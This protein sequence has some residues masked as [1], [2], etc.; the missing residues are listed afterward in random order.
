LS[1]KWI[2]LVTPV[3]ASIA[4]PLAEGLAIPVV[5]RDNRILDIVPLPRTP[6]GGAIRTALDKMLTHQVDTCWFD[7]GELLPP[8]WAACGDADWAGGTLMTC[9]YRVR[10]KGDAESVWE[11]VRTIG[12]DRGWYYAQPLWRLRGLLDRLVG[13]VGLRRGRRHPEELG[14]GDGIDF[15]RV[16]EIIEKRKL[17]LLA[18][19]K[20]PG[21]ATLTFEIDD[22][23]DGTTQL[24]LL[25][26]FLP[27]GIAGIFYWYSFYPF[28]ERIFFGMARAMARVTGNAIQGK[29]ERFTPRIADSC[30]LP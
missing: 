17:V 1:A 11:V 20:V 7:A 5:C 21:E 8:A 3:P 14:V 24:T 6:V 12:G 2:H 19:M 23:T 30:A 29:P 9:G 16:L 25:S 13:G 22:Y 10:I 26:R 15:W 27:Q 18:E 4:Q 28:H